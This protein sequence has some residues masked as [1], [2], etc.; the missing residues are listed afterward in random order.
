VLVVSAC[1][2]TRYS[3]RTQAEDH[4]LG[5]DAACLP[6]Q[7]DVVLDLLD[8]AR[9]RIGGHFHQDQPGL[10]IA[11]KAG[12]QQAIGQLARLDDLGFAGLARN[13]LPG[14][15][16]VQDAGSLFFQHPLAAGIIG[17]LRHGRSSR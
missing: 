13:D 15:G 7:P 14:A 11:G 3:L 16:H 17:L 5:K 4:R 9:L 8:D 2:G 10:I 6:D 12:L 1:D